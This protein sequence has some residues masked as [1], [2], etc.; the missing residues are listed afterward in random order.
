MWISSGS[1]IIYEIYIFILYIFCQQVKSHPGEMKTE[2]LPKLTRVG[3]CPC[4]SQPHVIFS[5][6]FACHLD[7]NL[8][9]TL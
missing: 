7:L 6:P 8:I 1:F 9:L 2:Q 4:K 3:S 5:V